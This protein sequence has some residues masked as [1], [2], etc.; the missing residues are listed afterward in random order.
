[1]LDGQREAVMRRTRSGGHKNV[2]Q[3]PTIRM[4]LKI[5]SYRRAAVRHE[6]R[7]P[8]QH[9]GQEPCADV[10]LKDEATAACVLRWSNL[11]GHDCP[12]VSW[13]PG[14]LR[15]RP[16]RPPSPPSRTHGIGFDQAPA[17]ER[18]APAAGSWMS[19]S[20]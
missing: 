19:R 17:R 14:W 1:A 2:I 18:A 4:S 15:A 10:V 3:E 11:S 8:H 5:H 16:S 9:G 13:P 6:D 7:L 12:P 20:W